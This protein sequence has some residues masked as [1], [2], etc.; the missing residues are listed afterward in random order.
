MRY[1]QRKPLLFILML[2]VLTLFIFPS[3]L[4]AQS[5]RVIYFYPTDQPSPNQQKLNEIGKIAGDVQSFYR[6]EMSDNNFGE[7]TFELEGTGIASQFT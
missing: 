5:V 6:K 4:S 7:K 2:S 3:L 1:F